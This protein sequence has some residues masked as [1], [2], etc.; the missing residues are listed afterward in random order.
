L[1]QIKA[2]TRSGKVAN[3]AVTATEALKVL[4][5]TQAQ[6]FLR[7]CAVL[8]QGVIISQAELEQAAR[9]EDR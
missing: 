4:R 9:R 5:E 2:T 1:Y 6:P 8:R 3:R 7:A